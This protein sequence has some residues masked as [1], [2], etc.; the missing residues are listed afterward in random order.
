[1]AKFSTSTSPPKHWDPLMG[2]AGK[3][4][5][6]TTKILRSPLRRLVSIV[7]EK[8]F[9]F[10][11]TKFKLSR[12]NFRLPFRKTLTELGNISLPF[13]RNFNWAGKDFSMT[14]KIKPYAPVIIYRLRDHSGGLERINRRRVH[15]RI[16]KTEECLSGVMTSTAYV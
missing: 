1:M 2:G 3:L 6:N 4:C 15:R 16:L 5:R 9:S 13:S 11:F 14:H 7:I 10:F 8:D 12:E